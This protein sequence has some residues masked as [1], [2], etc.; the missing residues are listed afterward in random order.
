MTKFLKQFCEKDEYILLEEIKSTEP[1]FNLKQKASQSFILTGVFNLLVQ[2]IQG[3]NLRPRVL[4]KPV[5][6]MEIPFN[7]ARD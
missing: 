7:E 2:R 1:L 5:N 4:S 3:I 6:N